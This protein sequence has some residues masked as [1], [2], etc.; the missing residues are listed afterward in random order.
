[1]E[2]LSLDEA[3]LDV[4][5]NKVNNPSASRIAQEIRERIFRETGLT[6]S[7]GVSY[8]KFIAKIASDINKPNGMTVI[9]PDKAEVFLEGLPIGK[10][11]GVGK[12][13]AARMKGLGIETGGDLKKL[14]LY[15]CIEH[16][17][18]S[19][20]Y[21]YYA[22]RG[23]DN[24]QVEPRRTRK[25]LGRENTFSKDLIDLGHIMDELERICQ[26][27]EEDCKKHNIG[28]RQ[29]TLKVKYHDFRLGTI[30]IQSPRGIRKRED[31]MAL[32]PGLLD[33]TDVARIPLRLL[34]VSL[35]KLQGD[36]YQKPQAQMELDFL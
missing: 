17:G 33:K 15:K 30:S 27:V 36:L 10:F 31:M 32:L 8:N 34:G 20:P 19:G 16:F 22:V 11:W 23:T 26:R 25:S 13:T 6:A 12:K 3:Y 35:S 5:Q 1:V 4:S 9:P 2:P 21:Y 18:K 28:G 24:R 7:A 14:E 29:L